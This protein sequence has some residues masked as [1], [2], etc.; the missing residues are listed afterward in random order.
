LQRPYRR[1]RVGHPRQD[2]LERDYVVLRQARRHVSGDDRPAYDLPVHDDDAVDYDGTAARRCPD[3][4]S[5]AR[6]EHP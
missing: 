4:H 6:N 3:H 2:F 1:L 5:R